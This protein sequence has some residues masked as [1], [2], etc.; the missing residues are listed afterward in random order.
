[1]PHGCLQNSSQLMLAVLYWM[2][3]VSA[4]LFSFTKPGV[5]LHGWNL[6]LYRMC[7]SIKYPYSTPQEGIFPTLLHPSGNLI[8][9]HRH[10]NV[11]KLFGLRSLPLPGISNPFCRE[12][13]D[14]FRN[15]TLSTCRL[16]CATVKG[17]E[18]MDLLLKLVF[19]L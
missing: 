9:L 5:I 8:N 2:E 3:H 1:M 6:T 14:I 19:I 17:R 18:I 11:F 10:I 15:Y 7:I 13:M 16:F 4:M 12:S